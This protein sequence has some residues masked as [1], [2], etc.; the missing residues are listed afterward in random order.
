MLA[1]VTD[2]EFCGP[3]VSHEV[4]LG[5]MA[6]LSVTDSWLRIFE[7]QM[8]MPIRSPGSGAPQALA[9]GV[10][11]SRRSSRFYSE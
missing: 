7:T 6:F 5:I 3:S 10:P 8:K 9:K 1:V 2:L 4:V 11:A